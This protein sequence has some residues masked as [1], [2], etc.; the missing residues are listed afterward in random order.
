MRGVTSPSSP[1][2]RG[3]RSARAASREGV[4]A[5]LGATSTGEELDARRQPHPAAARRPSPSRGRW[6]AGPEGSPISLPPFG[7]YRNGGIPLHPHLPLEG[8]G[9]LAKRDGRGCPAS[10]G[11]NRLAKKF[12]M[13]AVIPPRRCAAT[14][15][16]RG[17]L[18]S[19]ARRLSIF[20]GVRLAYGGSVELP[21]GGRGAQG[22]A[23][24]RGRPGLLGAQVDGAASRRGGGL[25][26]AGRSRGRTRRGLAHRHHRSEPSRAASRRPWGVAQFGSGRRPGRERR[27]ARAASPA[28]GSAAAG[29]RDA[30]KTGGA[31]LS[32]SGEVSAG[33]VADA[34]RA[35]R[36]SPGAMP[37]QPSR[38]DG[39]SARAKVVASVKARREGGRR[40]PEA[41]TSG[42]DDAFAAV[43][44]G[45][46]IG[47][48][49]SRRV[50]HGDGDG[51]LGQPGPQPSE[52]RRE[53][54]HS[55][56]GPARPSPRRLSRRRPWS[57]DL[58][59]K[60]RE[61]ARGS[62]AARRWPRWTAAAPAAD[63]VSTLSGRTSCR[64]GSSG[65]SGGSRP[66]MR[67]RLGL[68]RRICGRL[69]RFGGG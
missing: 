26:R 15:P 19:R 43:R 33:S 16:P 6:G 18:V 14:L 41:T 30:T 34:C 64:G 22:A 31:S 9:R 4:P 1:P 40:R 53:R 7:G 50:A 3:G 45:R 12:R 25:L 52:G 55:W 29:G 28:C 69:R 42:A 11:A 38:R 27:C 57:P 56:P 58:G 8:G 47:G 20:G 62:S 39:S 5:P 51:R 65:A 49:R 61:L 35:S 36:S 17:G 48:G 37:L 21:D 23:P 66:A 63:D 68:R 54:E 59:S 67:T 46:R 60:G 32:S 13:P 24:R 10:L 44:P 2:P